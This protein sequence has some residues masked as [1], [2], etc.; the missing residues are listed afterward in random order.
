[1]RYTIFEPCPAQV[2]NATGAQLA[3]NMKVDILLPSPSTALER[4]VQQSPLPVL[5]RHVEPSPEAVKALGSALSAAAAEVVTERRKAAMAA[6][7]AAA[8]AAVGGT[9]LCIHH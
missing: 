6:A 4:S 7:G 3:P 9:F 2:C 1:M 8:E 5:E